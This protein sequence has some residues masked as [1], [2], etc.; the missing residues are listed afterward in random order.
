MVLPS[1]ENVKK[2]DTDV[3]ISFLMEQ[4]SGW[5]LEFSEDTLKKLEDAEVNGR[6]FLKMSKDLRIS[7]GI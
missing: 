4:N 3:L 6:D 1:A 2:Y 7:L 5:N